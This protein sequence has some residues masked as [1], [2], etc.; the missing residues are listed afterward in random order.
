MPGRSA[1]RKAD[2]MNLS[3]PERTLTELDHVRLTRLLQRQAAQPGPIG[4]L[5]DFAHVVPSRAVEPDVVT[6]H[7]RVLLHDP[8]RDTRST[9]T[10]CYPE[11]AE[12]AAG[13]VS[14][15]SP[16]GRALLGLR[17]GEVA[18]WSTPDGGAQSAEIVA[19]PFQHEA[20]G[21]YTL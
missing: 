18:H 14:V 11:G 13:F 7:S 12:P 20:S 3:A 4:E 2:A 6:M 5:L 17:V 16:V 1:F 21:D 8:A 15:L 19:L 9:I 10:L